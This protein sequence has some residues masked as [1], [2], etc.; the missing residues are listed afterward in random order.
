[1]LKKYYDG[2]IIIKTTFIFAHQGFCLK[3]ALAHFD[4]IMC[5]LTA[6]RPY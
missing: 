3:E 6:R 2:L 5:I 4:M 1:M